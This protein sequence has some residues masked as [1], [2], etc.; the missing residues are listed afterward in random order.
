MGQIWRIGWKLPKKDGEKKF[1]PDFTGGKICSRFYR[2]KNLFQ[3]LQEE[4]FVP[5]FTG[6]KICPRYYRGKILF[7][8]LAK[9]RKLCVF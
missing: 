4:K 7:Q 1:V 9:M 8:N 2:G 5:D 3:I 6:G